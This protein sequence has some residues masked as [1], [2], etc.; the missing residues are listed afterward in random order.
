MVTERFIWRH[1]LI[2]VAVFFG[3]VIAEYAG[4]DVWF[5]SIFFDA[6]QHV[7]TY[8]RTWLFSTLLHDSARTLIVALALVNLGLIIASYWTESLKPHRKHFVF[9]F[10]GAVT[11]PVIVAIMKSVTHIYIPWDLQLF[12]GNRP[13]VRLFDASPLNLPPGQAFP[14]GHSSAGFAYL[15]LYFALAVHQHPLRYLALAGVIFLGSL[16]ALTQEI[17]GA[18]FLSH[19]LVSL[20]ICWCVSLAMAIGFYR[21]FETDPQKVDV[22][23]N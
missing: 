7:W 16:F 15:S 21:S 23:A 11:G 4:V 10:L 20:C 5:A 13:Y 2:A 19:D 3:A 9:L 17:R 8:R 1:L 6:S 22:N 18:H 12:G 14:G